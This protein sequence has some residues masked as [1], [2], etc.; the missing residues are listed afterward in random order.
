[1]VCGWAGSLACAD[2]INLVAGTGSIGYGERQGRKARVGGWGEIFSDEGSAYWTALQGLNAFTRM[3]DGRMPVGA[4]RRI[5]VEA[6]GLE[7]DLAI[8]ARVMGNAGMTRDEVAAL[9]P[10]VSRAA[11]E[12]D[13]Q[14]V[15]ILDRAGWELAQIA[16]A[17]RQQL[18]F[19]D[20]ER[21]LLSW[22]GGVLIKQDAVRAALLHHL[23]QQAP[24][25]LIAPRHEPGTGAALYAILL[26]SR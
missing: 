1:M 8:C 11:Q 18:R 13:G 6:M 5:F 10:L 22:S 25:E 15:A 16:R 19:D 12:G 21:V 24:Y 23:A 14:A 17:L 26:A 3:S 4:L 20:Q 9:A 2:G 7:S